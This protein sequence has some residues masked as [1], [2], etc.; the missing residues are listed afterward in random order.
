VQS[1]ANQ[2]FTFTPAAGY[3]VAGVLVDGVSKGTVS[4]YTFTNVTGNHIIAVTFTLDV[5]AITATA[6][7]NGGIDPAGVTTVS[8]GSSITYNIIPA[9]GY[10]VSYLL[11]DGSAFGAATTFTFNN[12]TANHTIAAYFTP[13]TYAITASAGANG[14]ISPAGTVN[15]N[16]GTNKTYTITP[17]TGYHV[18]DVLVDG[19]SVGA[20]TTYTFTSVTAAHT[21]SATFAANPAVTI[22]ASA[23]PNGTISPAG[24]VALPGGANQTF[25]LTPD[26][27]YRVADLLVD[28]VSVGAVN[29]YTF[30]DVATDHTIEASFTLDVYTVTAT[31]GANGS[32]TPVGVTTLNRGDSITY[33][34]TPDPGYR[35]LN[36]L[37]DG[38]YKEAATSYTFDSVTANHTISP[39]FALIQ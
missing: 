26:Y 38:V 30:T 6:Q 18:D 12:V 37:V 32:I 16:H 9:T 34:I 36:V 25:T 7:A 8:R 4:S 15:V 29:N 24:A 21:I 13:I 3:R 27:G 17:A 20:V 35:V 10:K 1:G 11:I 39:T 14:G 22:T 19:V 23:G 31:A 28:G 2:T 33:T 5:F